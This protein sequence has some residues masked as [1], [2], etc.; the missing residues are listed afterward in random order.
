MF[1]NNISITIV[2][3]R[4]HEHLFQTSF[5]DAG[6]RARYT[7]FGK[8]FTFENCT[9]GEAKHII[10]IVFGSTHHPYMHSFESTWHNTSIPGEKEVSHIHAMV[11]YR[12]IGAS[13][14]N[15]HIE[16]DDDTHGHAVIDGKTRPVVY[17]MRAQGKYKDTMQWHCEE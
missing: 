7:S 15:V 3:T 5:D 11:W 13:I 14:H 8:S 9:P 16:L 17:K 1:I 6:Y 2:T 10:E 4:G 12:G